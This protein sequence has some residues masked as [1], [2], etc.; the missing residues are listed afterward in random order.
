MLL[1]KLT[2]S[3]YQKWKLNEPKEE[4]KPNK[5]QSLTMLFKALSNLGLTNNSSNINN[6]NNNNN[7]LFLNQVDFQQPQNENSVSG[8]MRMPTRKSVTFWGQR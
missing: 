8:R 5:N 6:S 3:F 2:C 1:L 4:D 7:N